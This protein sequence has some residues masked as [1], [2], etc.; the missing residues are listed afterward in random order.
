MLSEVYYTTGVQVLAQAN[1]S[2][3]TGRIWLDNVTCTGNEKAL[4]NCT[5]SISGNNSC[6]HN[7]YAGVRC[8]SGCVEGDVRLVEGAT[9]LE[10]RVE[11][12][13]NSMWGTVCY[14]RWDKPD[15]RVV[16]RQLGLSVAGMYVI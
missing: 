10:G 11:I 2:A 7:Q 13:K 12:C 6:S 1:N 16:C 4:T 8:P 15:A 9:R 14:N 3:V 5:V